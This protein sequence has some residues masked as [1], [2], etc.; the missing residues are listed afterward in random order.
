M[1]FPDGVDNK[2]SV[3]KAGEPGL[4]PGLG[5]FPGEGHDYPLQYSHLENSTDRGAWQATVL[6]VA[7]SQ[8][9]L[10]DEHFNFTLSVYTFKLRLSLPLNR[11]KSS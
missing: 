10:S 2:E 5:R 3:C 6:G 8:T 1:G 4:I 7:K 9:R 11:C